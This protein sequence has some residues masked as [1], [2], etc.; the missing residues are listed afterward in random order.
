MAELRCRRRA[1]TLP[2]DSNFR[3]PQERQ[4]ALPDGLPALE[5]LDF[6]HQSHK[7]TIQSLATHLLIYI[8]H[9]LCFP[10]STLSDA[11]MN[12]HTLP[13]GYSVPSHL[14]LTPL[15]LP[16]SRYLRMYSNMLLVR[17]GNKSKSSWLSQDRKVVVNLNKMRLPF[18]RIIQMTPFSSFITTI[19]QH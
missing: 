3:S 2:A 6:S 19:L 10:V 15:F 5:I 14:S 1:G 9:C 8:L 7:C 17:K 12:P 18:L 13:R 11:D 4:P 16:P